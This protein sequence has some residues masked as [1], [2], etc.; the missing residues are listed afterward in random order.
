M[1]IEYDSEKNLDTRDFS[2]LKPHFSL[3]LIFRQFSDYLTIFNTLKL[4][5]RK[6]PGKEFANFVLCYIRHPVPTF[7]IGFRPL[8]Y[9]FS[10]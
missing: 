9:F 4:R 10:L 5:Y 6:T 3:S 2:P 8:K 7:E 1:E